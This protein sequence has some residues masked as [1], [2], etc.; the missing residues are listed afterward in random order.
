MVFEGVP[1]VTEHGPNSADMGNSV[2][3]TWLS[4]RLSQQELRPYAGDDVTDEDVFELDQAGRLLSVRVGRSS[5][6]TASN[7]LRAQPEMDQLLSHLIR[8]RK[9]E[10]SR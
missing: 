10:A 8:A 7:Y 5:R 9:M 6:T 2:C 3:R 1:I 4:G